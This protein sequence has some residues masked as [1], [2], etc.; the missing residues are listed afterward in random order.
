MF[1]FIKEFTEVRIFSVSIILLVVDLLVKI[2]ALTSLNHLEIFVVKLTLLKLS[3][4]CP[5]GLI[6]VL[7]GRLQLVK[8]VLQNSWVVF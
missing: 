8:E 1:K 7:Q 6:F 3:D 5:L 2:T 4:G